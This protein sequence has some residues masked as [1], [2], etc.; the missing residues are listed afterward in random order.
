MK[1]T[2]MASL[3]AW[4]NKSERMPLILYGARQVGKTWL[5]KEFGAKHFSDTLYINFEIDTALA[6]DFEAD[7][8]PE[9]LINLLEAYAGRTIVADTTLIVFDEIQ[10]CP[11]ALT[12]LKYFRENAP[13][14]RIIAA[15]S[16]LGVS[17][18][19]RSSSFPAGN[20]ELLTLNPLDFEEFL[21]ALGEDILV[22]A[23]REGFDT[24]R[25]LPEALHGKALDLYRIYL[26][27]GGMPAAINA[28]LREKKVM[29]SS[30]VQQAILSA[31]TADMTK[32]AL[33]A[34]TSKVIA[35]Y[36]S[37]PAQLAKENRKFQYKVVKK[38]GSA[39][40]F[41]A[42]IDWLSASSLVEKCER[43]EG[44]FIP[45]SAYRDLSAFKLYMND[46]GLLTNKSGIPTSMMLSEHAGFTFLGAMA[47]NYVAQTLRA[48]GYPLYYWES[49]SQ[50]EVD[51]ILQKGEVLIPIEVKSGEHAKSRSLSVYRER[52]KPELSIRL[53]T[54]QF[55]LQNGLKSL[56][57]Y[58][59][60]CL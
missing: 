49:G 38:G 28:Y 42:S 53:S 37:I 58:A 4:K 56:P 1:R 24:N 57:L 51:F 32:Y 19:N 46:V 22:T 17:I 36:D 41:G 25:P 54:R 45:L 59:V 15:G 7:L 44:A 6:K 5:I 27:V 23:I 33:P 48:K 9:R 40:L 18:K 34:E 55:G 14:Y 47:E 11:R 13:E 35:C 30:L 12:S 26:V 39:T 16:A 21:E 43:I 50:A 20:V 8:Q 2:L 3:I 60:F 29:D 52:Y 31:Y 10:A